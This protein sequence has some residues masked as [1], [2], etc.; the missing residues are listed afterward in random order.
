MT[1]DQNVLAKGEIASSFQ[2]CPL[3]GGVRVTGTVA[4]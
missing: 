1:V 4:E 2:V 3:N